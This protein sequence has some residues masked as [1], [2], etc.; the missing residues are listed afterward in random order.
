[1]DPG[2][3]GDDAWLWSIQEFIEV[4]NRSQSDSNK[5]ANLYNQNTTALSTVNISVET[6]VTV[7]QRPITQHDERTHVRETMLRGHCRTAVSSVHTPKATMFVEVHSSSG[8]TPTDIYRHRCA[9]AIVCYFK[10]SH[11]YQPKKP[12]CKTVILY[13]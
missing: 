4:Y 11:P 13:T 8:S 9:S 3:D 6:P 12:T 2:D 10:T 5:K 7:L 1:L